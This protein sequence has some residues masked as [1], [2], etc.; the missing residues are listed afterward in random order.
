MIK[1][2]IVSPSSFIKDY[3]TEK[4]SCTVSALS[5]ST[6][7]SFEEASKVAFSAGRK[8]N[9][10]FASFKLIDY[11]N[12]KYQSKFEPCK[13]NKNITLNKFLSLYPMGKYYVRKRGHAFAVVDG[14]VVDWGV[15]VA[16]KTKVLAAWAYDNST[17]N[18]T[19]DIRPIARYIKSTPIVYVNEVGFDREMFISE[20]Y[21]NGK[22]T[23]KM[24]P[25][26]VTGRMVTCFGQNLRNKVFKYGSVEKLLD[27]FVSK[28]AK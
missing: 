11:W 6:G 16:F 3:K 21:Y 22:P 12:N 20:Y 28:Y 9:K 15:K 13:I 27:N 7:I 18:P 5:A 25:C 23:S 26:T 10:G 14:V 1:K 19:I 4:S 17:P 8:F 24:I 2:E